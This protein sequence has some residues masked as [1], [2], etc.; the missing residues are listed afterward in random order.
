MTKTL[1]L[2]GS[3]ALVAACANPDECPNRAKDDAIGVVL[4]GLPM[5]S[6]MGTECK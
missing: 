5:G 6:I 2:I 3:L 4:I 1:F